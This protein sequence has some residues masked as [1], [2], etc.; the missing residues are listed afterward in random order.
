MHP[1]RCLQW[2]DKSQQ[3]Q[4]VPREN[5][6]GHAENFLSDEN[7]AAL[8]TRAW[9]GSGISILGEFPNSVGHCPERPELN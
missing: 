6:P 3:S 1:S 5:P 8:E 7:D 4:V 9:N 2:K